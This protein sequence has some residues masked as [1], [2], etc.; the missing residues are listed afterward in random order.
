MQVTVECVMGDAEAMQFAH[1]I[2]AF[3]MNEGYTVVG[4]NMCEY[5]EPV[6]GQDLIPGKEGEGTRVVIGT[7]V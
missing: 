3:L 7:R 2:K 5:S 4:V 6:K 1:E